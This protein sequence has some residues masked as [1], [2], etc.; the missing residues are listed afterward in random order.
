MLFI[1]GGAIIMLLKGD[2][3]PDSG[4]KEVSY[5]H[6]GSMQGERYTVTLTYLNEKEAK[7]VTESKPYYNAANTICEYV[8]DVKYLE[9]IE[10]MMKEYEQLAASQRPN[11]EYQVLDGPSS[12]L[13]FSFFDKT[14][15][16]VESEKDMTNKQNE[17]MNLIRQYLYDL[18]DGSEG[19][20]FTEERRI[21]FS[22]HNG[23]TLT[24]N[25]RNALDEYD[26]DKILGEQEFKR[27]NDNGF[28][29]QVESPMNS[30]EYPPVESNTVGQLVYDSE[31]ASLILFYDDFKI[32]PSFRLIGELEE[33]SM[34]HRAMIG[35][36]EEGEYT[37]YQLY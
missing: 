20:V 35:D 18:A 28:I 11:S 24:L 29:Y 21:S 25:I 30:E 2:K 6:G 4:L 31:N 36:I 5:Y 32:L 37:F 8:V 34:E 16:R 1:A 15:F 3:Y 9:K 12:H 27:Y 17:G 19:T 22:L 10:V 7:L 23:Y 33:S 14:F 13:T 26:F